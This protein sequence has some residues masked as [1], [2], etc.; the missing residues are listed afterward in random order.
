MHHYS[1]IIQ[2]AIFLGVFIAGVID[3]SRNDRD[4]I[5]GILNILLFQAVQPLDGGLLDSHH[6]DLISHMP[7]NIHAA[8]SKFDLDNKTVIYTVCLRCHCTYTPYISPGEMAAKYLSHCTN[9][10]DPSSNHCGQLL[11]RRDRTGKED[12]WKPIK[13]FVYHSFH[14]YLASLLSRKDLE[15]AMDKTC[16]E[17]Q[18]LI[19]GPLPSFA[20]DVSQAEF[21][22]WFQGPTPGWFVVDRENEGHYVFYLNVN[23]FNIEGMCIQ[24]ALAACGLISMVCLNLPPHLC[25]KPEYMYIAGIIPGPKQPMETELNHYFRP[26]INDMEQSWK[27]GVRY[28]TTASFLEGHI[29]RSATAIAVMDLPAAWHSSQLA[30][31][32]ANIYC[33]VCKCRQ[34]STLGRVNHY[35]WKLW[36]DEEIHQHAEQWKD[37]ATLKEHKS[38]F[39]KHGTHYS[40]LW[41]LPYWKPACQLVVDPIH[42]NYKT[43]IPIH[44]RQILLLTLADAATPIPPKPAFSHNFVTIN[45]N[46]ATSNDMNKTEVKKVSAIHRLLTEV[47]GGTTDKAGLA[48]LQKCLM[49]KNTKALIFVCNDLQLHPAPKFMTSTKFYKKDWVSALVKWVGLHTYQQSK[50]TDCL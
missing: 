20:S 8:L 9:H 47:L 18:G 23:T 17:L 35:N 42:C 28:T 39:N 36:D 16:G 10:T 13:P 21:L 46:D 7:N 49:D 45:K 22:W 1:I 38:I 14:D 40:E 32:S 24:G 33:T 6:E 19:D 27:L 26:L 25:Y 30:G 3:A 12:S 31:H 2:I 43:L 4:F 50:F 34:R 44:F 5:M 15:E 37:V 41:W 29:T 11:L 48:L